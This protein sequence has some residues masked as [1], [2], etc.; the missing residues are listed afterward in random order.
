[1]DAAQQ[2]LHS[3]QVHDW[4]A[5]AAL[6]LML[7]LQCV[8]QGN[9][10]LLTKLWNK[11]PD[12]WRWLPA[13][14]SGAATGFTTAF[15]NGQPLGVALVASV[16]GVFGISFPAMGIHAVAK[17]SPIRIDGGAGGKKPDENPR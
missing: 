7:V 17:E 5:A 2:I 6:I 8:R 15:A 3:F 11:I 9:I 12:G 1:M 14:L 13:F 10:P 4:Y 16:G